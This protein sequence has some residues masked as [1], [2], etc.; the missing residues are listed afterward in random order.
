LINK[1][2][3][4]AP[5]LKLQPKKFHVKTKF[6]KTIFKMKNKMMM[7]LLES[8]RLARTNGFVMVG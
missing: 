3:K 1:K 4:A 5:N 6:I 2:S 8:E 7:L